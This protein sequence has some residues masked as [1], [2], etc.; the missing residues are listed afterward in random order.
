MIKAVI[1]DVGGVL[2]RTEDPEPRRQLEARLGLN[3]GDAEMLVFNSPQGRDAQLGAAGSE[4]LWQSVAAE[5]DLSPL[6]LTLFQ[7]DF[8]GGDRLDEE[9]IDFIRRLRGPYQTAI[10]SN[11]MDE[12]NHNLSHVYPC[13]DAFDLVVGSAYEGIMKPDPAIYLRTLGRLGRAPAEAVFIDDFAHNVAGAQAV[14]MYA[15]H[16]RPGLDLPAELA[17]L[18]VTPQS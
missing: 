6:E 16:F 4:D 15:V 2:I 8:F 3:P 1:F 18:G 13:A 7:R 10:I 17:S 12:L 5:L 9:L 14:G 11:Y